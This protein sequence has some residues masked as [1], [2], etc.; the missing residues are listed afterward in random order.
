MTI[1]MQESSRQGIPRPRPLFTLG[2]RI[3]R[4]LTYYQR[5]I[6]Y[7]SGGKVVQRAFQASQLRR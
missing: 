3:L 4:Y 1:S 5:T 6:Y 2:N 7:W